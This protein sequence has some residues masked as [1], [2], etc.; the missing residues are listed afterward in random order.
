MKLELYFSP[1]ACSFVPHVAL[2]TIKAA[3]GHDFE[4]KIIKLHKGEQHAPDYLAL[5]PN[6]QVPLL[7]VDGQP[8][9]QIVAMC[10]FLDRSFPQAN[11]LPKDSFARAQALSTLSWFNNSVHP[12]FTHFFMPEKFTKDEAAKAAIKSQA[13]EDFR[14]HISRIDAMV[15]AANGGFLDG[16]SAG[17]VDAYALTLY[18]WSGFCGVNP[19]TVPSLRAHVDRLATLPAF[20]AAIERERIPL[21]T[22]KAA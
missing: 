9:S 2:E 17:F 11:L 12:T 20:A 18:R 4:P 5:N 22:F 1:G 15:K 21:H 10:E 13:A 6:G 19:E 16:A 14:G 3:T 8:L 7:V